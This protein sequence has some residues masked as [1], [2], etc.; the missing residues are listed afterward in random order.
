MDCKVNNHNFLTNTRVSFKR[1]KI[2]DK[3]PEYISDSKS[4][5]WLSRRGV[6]RYSDHWG[7]IASCDWTLEGIRDYYMPVP[8]CGYAKWGDFKVYKYYNSLKNIN[9][10]EVFDQF[11]GSCTTILKNII[12]YN[13][14]KYQKGSLI[15]QILKKERKIYAKIKNKT[16]RIKFGFYSKYKLENKIQKKINNLEEES[17]LRLLS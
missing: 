2:P 3:E 8:V 4:K 10:W 16:Y 7:L 6:Y 12:F 17:T 11:V 9:N 1:C 5:Y 13:D 15:I 14:E